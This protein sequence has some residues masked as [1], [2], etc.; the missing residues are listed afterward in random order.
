[1]CGND[2]STLQCLQDI[3]TRVVHHIAP[4]NS[5]LTATYGALQILYDDDDDDDD[6]DD[7]YK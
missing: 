2:A 5:I 3:T 7:E 4:T 1:V 6:D